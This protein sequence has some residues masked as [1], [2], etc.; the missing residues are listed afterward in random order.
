M[1]VP[2]SVEIVFRSFQAGFLK[3]LDLDIYHQLKR[4]AAKRMYRFLD[5]RFHFSKSLRFDL[6]T[7]ACEHIG[8]SRRY[9]VAQLKRRLKPAIAELEQVEYLVPAPEKERFHRL[10]RGEWQVH[11]VR[12]AKPRKEACSAGRN[13]TL[14]DR[15]VERGVTA[16]AAE[17]LVAQYAAGRIEDKIA[18]FD[19]LRRKNDRR[20][21]QNPAGFLV[22]SIREDYLPPVG[23]QEKQVGSVLRQHGKEDGRAISAPSPKP[24]VH[25]CDEKANARREYLSRLSDSQRQ[26]LEAEALKRARRVP[27]EGYRRALTAGNDQLAQ[28]YSEVMVDQYLS[29]MFDMDSVNADNRVP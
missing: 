24:R 18:V 16:T 10:R 23:L 8:L 4:A 26:T 6:S 2:R 28:Y 29:E 21:S 13:P 7:F 1:C 25:V 9:D 14:A 5:K 15:L 17:N 27:A 3:K 19:S 20:I 11:F 12:A 22:Q